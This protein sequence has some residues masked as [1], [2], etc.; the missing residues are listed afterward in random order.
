MADLVDQT[1]QRQVVLS[2]HGFGRQSAGGASG[3]VIVGQVDHRQRWGRARRR[4]LRVVRKKAVHTLSRA[5]LKIEAR[6][7]RVRRQL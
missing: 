2:N 1:P 7:A 4:T 3:G 5:H 6:E